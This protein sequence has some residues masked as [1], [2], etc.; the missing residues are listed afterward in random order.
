MTS[1]HWWRIR[2]VVDRL[3]AVVA[4][5]LLA[6]VVAV[7]AVLVKRE[8]GGPAFIQVERMGEGFRPFGMWKLRTMRANRPDGRASGPVLTAEHDDRITDV[9]R[10]LRSY[11]LDEIPQLLNVARGEMVLIGPR[12]ETPE[13]VEETSA[14]W[15]RLLRVPPGIAGPTQLIVSDWERKLLADHP[16][17]GVYPQEILPVKLAIDEWYLD[18]TSPK[19]DLEVGVALIKRFVPGSQATRMRGRVRSEVPATTDAMRAHVNRQRP[20]QADT[21]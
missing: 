1:D 16:A 3:V 19:R 13:Y 9:G 10:R 20:N 12:P 18:T 11:H 4:G 7:L 2:C 15:V 17:N 8:D 14:Q 21:P 6:P 5:I